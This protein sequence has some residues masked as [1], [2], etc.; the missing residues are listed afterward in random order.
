MTKDI[1]RTPPKPKTEKSQSIEREESTSH[2]N[3]LT[4]EQLRNVTGGGGPPTTVVDRR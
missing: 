4:G 2:D 1:V 3:E